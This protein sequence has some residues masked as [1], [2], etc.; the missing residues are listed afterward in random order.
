MPIEYEP[1]RGKNR[2]KLT[3]GN[4]IKTSISHLRLH[5][6]LLEL[7]QDALPPQ[8]E[9]GG[10]H[11]ERRRPRHHRGAT[12]GTRARGGLRAAALRR[13]PVVIYVNER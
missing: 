4:I 7:L 8:Q 12:R 10:V 5:L 1:P 13:T 9:V 11:N 3:S 6:G 2:R